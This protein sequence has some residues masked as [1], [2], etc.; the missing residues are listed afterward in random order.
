MLTGGFPSRSSS[1]PSWLGLALE[2]TGKVLGVGRRKRVF[3]LVGGKGWVLL[4]GHVS[5]VHASHCNQLHTGGCRS[6][7]QGVGVSSV[8]SRAAPEPGSSAGFL[9]APAWAVCASL[10]SC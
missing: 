8:S 5:F 1:L 6:G 4:K 3:V 7:C 9:A 10:Q 2:F